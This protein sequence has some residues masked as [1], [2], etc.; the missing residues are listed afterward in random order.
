M[1]AV[2]MYHVCQNH[3]CDSCMCH[4]LKKEKVLL[5]MD[6]PHVRII[7]VRLIARR[8]DNYNEK[9]FEKFE[10]DAATRYAASALSVY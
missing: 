4:E 2:I 5:I 10:S 6:I 7:N 1:N 8:P 3:E 9:Y